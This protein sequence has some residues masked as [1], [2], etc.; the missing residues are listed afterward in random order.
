MRIKDSVAVITGA[1]GGIG[2]ALAVELA[3]REVGGL[4]LADRSEEAGHVADSVNELTGRNLAAAYVGDVTDAEF[5]GRRVR[6][7]QAPVRAAVHLRAD[8]G[9][10]PRPPGGEVR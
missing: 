9:R 5:P 8:R 10:D 6:R 2:R 1:A 3:K 4:A 7:C